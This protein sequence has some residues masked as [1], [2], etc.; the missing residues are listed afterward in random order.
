M[1]WLK[2]V[3]KF[4]C[5]AFVRLGMLCFWVSLGWVA[6]SWLVKMFGLVAADPVFFIIG[7]VLMIA[8]ALYSGE[9]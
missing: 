6:L 1:K 9:I 4:L 7:I 3:T 5:K 8:A 2:K